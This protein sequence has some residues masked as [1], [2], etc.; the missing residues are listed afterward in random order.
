MRSLVRFWRKKLWC[1]EW[2]FSAAGSW[3]K[4]HL[5]EQTIRNCRLHTLSASEER[6]VFRKPLPEETV[7]FLG[8]LCWRFGCYLVDL[9][10][11]ERVEVLNPQGRAES[12][13]IKIPIHRP[14]PGSNAVSYHLTALLLPGVSAGP[15]LM[16]NGS[17]ATPDGYGI[18]RR[19][20]RSCRSISFSCPSLKKMN[21]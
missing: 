10:R 14:W 21:F 2:P 18:C 5:C 11:C 20:N 4:N 12:V 16:G 1:L 6:S 13:T 19:L 7:H 17:L 8:G 9:K 3:E 15:Q